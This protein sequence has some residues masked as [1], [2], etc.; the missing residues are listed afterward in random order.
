MT[1]TAWLWTAV[2]P[3]APL[4]VPSLNWVMLAAGVL[5]LVSAAM[6]LAVADR[7]AGEAEVQSPSALADGAFGCAA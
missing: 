5:W 4:V 7:Q 2:I 6:L 1:W 3:S